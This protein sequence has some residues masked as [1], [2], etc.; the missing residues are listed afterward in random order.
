MNIL[1]KNEEKPE[2]IGETDEL[3]PCDRR[4]LL[5]EIRREIYE[6]K[7]YEAVS[8]DHLADVSC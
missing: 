4:V 3:K 7:N 5:K 6:V 2:V 8:P 1:Q